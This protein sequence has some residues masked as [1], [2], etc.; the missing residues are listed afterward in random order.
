MAAKIA[1]IVGSLRKDSLNRK[2]ANVLIEIAPPSLSM[3]FV[4]IGALSLY[5][6]DFDP[7][8]P[9]EWTA[10]RAAIKQADAVLFVS[11]EYNRSVPGVL[12]NAIDIGSRP[13]GQ[14]VWEKKPAAVVTASPG[15]A[16]GSSSALN[17]RQTL[18]ALNMPT[19]PQPEVYL[20]RADKLFDEQGQMAAGTKEFLG[21]F[22]AAYAAWVE[23]NKAS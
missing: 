15:A 21:K 3:S 11:P 2:V 23:R 5:N 17:I 10:F 20:S 9:A 14:S 22:L 19:L 8:P 1:V 12:K 7:N 16:G 6:A 4:E 18:V 13:P